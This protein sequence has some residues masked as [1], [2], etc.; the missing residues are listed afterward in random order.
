[1][2]RNN[3]KKLSF[4]TNDF[5]ISFVRGLSLKMVLLLLTDFTASI[6][7]EEIIFIFKKFKKKI[8]NIFLFVEE[9]EK[10]KF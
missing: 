1:M 8:Q 3:K 2:N 6:I 4:D 5:D 10:I 7:G 9:E